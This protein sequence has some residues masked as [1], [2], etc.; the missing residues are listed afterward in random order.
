MKIGISQI[1]VV[2]VVLISAG[3]IIFLVSQRSVNV[4]AKYREVVDVFA[5]AKELNLDIEQFKKD[6][7]S[8]EV[9]DLVAKTKTEGEQKMGAQVGTPSFFINGER[10][11]GQGTIENLITELQVAIQGKITENEKPIV[12]E[13]FD[14][15]CIH[16]SNIDESINTMVKT[17]GDSI[18]FTKKYYPFLRPSSTTY[19]YAGESAKRQGKFS[20][21]SSILFKRIHNK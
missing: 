1:L 14:Y 9:H 10:F 19:A 6:I 11:T 4:E 21:Y 8:S 7:D 16:C 12:E 17:F 3:L 20:E 2:L 15:N 13:F 5:I 18:I